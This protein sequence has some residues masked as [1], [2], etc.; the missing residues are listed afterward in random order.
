M[1][2]L[3][4]IRRLLE[5]LSDW[6]LG[7]TATLGGLGLFL[8]AFLDSSF[9]S[10]PVAND[11]IVIR[12]AVDNP[13]RM[14][15]YALMATLGSLAGCL[16]IYSLARKGGEAYF[17]KSA[18]PRAER[19]RGWLVRNAFLS[20]AIPSILPPPMPFKLFVIAAGVFQVPLRVFVISLLV[21]RGLRYFAGGI[22]AVRYGQQAIDLL[23][24]HPLLFTLAMLLLIVVSFALTRLIFR[25][26]PKPAA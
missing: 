14:P 8:V 10:L 2:L 20:V 5:R 25:A 6:A 1:I 19:I 21:G 13:A 12:L 16:V 9:L 26:P 24:R 7:L 22:L 17:Q 11:L 3:G 18:G 23:K 15:Y 4:P